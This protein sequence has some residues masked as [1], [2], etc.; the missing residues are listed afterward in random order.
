MKKKFITATKDILERNLNIDKLP[1]SNKQ[2]VLVYD[3]NSKLSIEVSNWYINNLE[4][5]QNSLLINFD[6]INKQELKE[7]L[8]WLE[9]DS[10]VILVSSTNFRLDDFRI[11]LNLHNKWIW[12]L[13]HNHLGYIKNN[14]IENYADAILYKGDY[15][16]KIWNKLKNMSDNANSMTFICFDNS[17][18]K[19]EWWFEDMKMNTWNFQGKKRWWSFPIWEVFTEAKDFNKVNWELSI[20]AFPDDKLQVEFTKPF[21]I[22]I[23]NSMIICDDLNCPKK[24]KNNLNMISSFEDNE[25]MFRELGFWLNT[26]I[27]REKP[28]SDINTFERISWFHISLW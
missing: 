21:K 11:R 5:L 27:T 7:K 20:Y 12:C 24:F 10:T 4:K 17:T 28:L 14:E 26:W 6:K 9:K 8:L 15:Y 13:E 22:K 23:K 1:Y 16:K 3:L 19:I 18:L 25:V 2:I